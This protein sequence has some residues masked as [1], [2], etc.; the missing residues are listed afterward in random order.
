MLPPLRHA[1]L[2]G[3]ALAATG[4]TVLAALDRR[5]RPPAAVPGPVVHARVP[6]PPPDLVDDFVRHVGGDAARCA[7]RL[8][9]ALWP[10]WGMAVAQEALRVLPYPLLRVLNG[11]CRLDQRAPLPR[12]ERLLLRAQVLKVDDNDRRVL[13]HTRVVTGTAAMPDAL[14]ADTY[15]VLPRRSPGRAPAE[16]A[17]VPA[18]ADLL[19]RWWLPA[20]AGLGFAV[21]TGDFNPLHWLPPYARA[22]GFPG[23]ILHGFSTM[24]RTWEALARAGGVR[25]LDVKFTR[26]LA[27]PAQV[28]AW[29]LGNAV[30]VGP[31][32]G[33]RAALVGSFEA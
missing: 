25:V 15:A 20:D 9:P 13:L 8:P 22:A 31:A 19:E 5:A 3:P 1:L 27:L 12:G 7:G 6:A 2:Q 23:T 18:G 4:R 24:A 29:R 14:V 17:V 10:Q 33:E 26:P 32:P 11:G 16:P 28:G 30:A 21:L